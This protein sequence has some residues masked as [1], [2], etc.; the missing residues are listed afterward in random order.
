MIAYVSVGNSDD[1]LT[2][3]RWHE[4]ILTLDAVLM[5]AGA[6][7]HD[8]YFS[9]PSAPWQNVCWC[10]EL[11][12]GAPALK[13]RLS[14]LAA[15]YGQDAIAWAQVLRTDMLGPGAPSPPVAP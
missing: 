12:R 15:E 3:R 6:K 5:D 8:S 2:Q 4:L 1:K 13:R 11:D 7:F 9:A 10:I 14:A